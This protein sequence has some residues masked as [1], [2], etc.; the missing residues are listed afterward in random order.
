MTSG[1]TGRDSQT[2]QESQD[3]TNGCCQ[4]TW[5]RPLHHLYWGL[6]GRDGARGWGWGVRGNL[7][8]VLAV[9]GV[10]RIALVRDIVIERKT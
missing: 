9:A 6:A 3:R 1:V 8:I 7:S 2:A 4:G 5:S 10:N